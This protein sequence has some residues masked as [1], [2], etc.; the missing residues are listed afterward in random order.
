MKR[1][2]GCQLHLSFF[3]LKTKEVF[4]RPIFECM[5]YGGF[6]YTEA[7]NLPLN[8][9]RWFINE[10]VDE[11]KRSSGHEDS[12]DNPKPLPL[13]QREA[14]PAIEQSRARQLN[15]PSARA[16]RGENRQHIPSRLIRF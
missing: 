1:R 10:I 11:M 12:E 4:L 6:T 5:Y 14:N 2:W 8:F 7:Y 15:S 13:R 16:W 9:R 3:G